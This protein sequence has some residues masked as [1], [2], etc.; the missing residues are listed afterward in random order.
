MCHGTSLPISNRSAPLPSRQNSKVS[1]SALGE[2]L[3]ALPN[4]QAQKTLFC[5]LLK[6]ICWGGERLPF[7]YAVYSF[8]LAGIRRWLWLRHVLRPWPG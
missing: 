4:Y 6:S 7:I 5:R 3:R 8:I 1:E 2:I